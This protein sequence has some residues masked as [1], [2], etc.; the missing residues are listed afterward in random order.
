MDDDIVVRIRKHPDNAL[1]NEAADEIVR[2]RGLITEAML[3]QARMITQIE[4]FADE[5]RTT[6][7]HRWNQRHGK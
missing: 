5:L 2:Q 6:E 1:A 4:K 7:Q 3:T